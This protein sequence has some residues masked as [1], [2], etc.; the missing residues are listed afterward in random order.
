MPASPI[1]S[2][3]YQVHPM[4]N[5]SSRSFVAPRLIALLLTASATAQWQQQAPTTHPTARR[6]AAMTYLL[7]QGQALLFGG[8]GNPTASNETWLCDGSNWTLYTPATVPGGRQEFEM[9]YDLARTRAVFYGGSGTGTSLGTQ[10]WEFDGTD[11]A[12]IATPTNPGARSR[13]GLSYDSARSRVVMF[14]GVGGSLGIPTN[15]TWEYDGTTWLQVATAHSPGA[16]DRPAMCYDDTLGKTVLFG[17]A[18]SSSIYDLTWV[19]DGVD[20]T[21]VPITGAKPLQRNAAKM[22]YDSFRGVCVLTGGQTA[23]VIYDDTWEFDGTNWTQQVSPKQP[24]RDHSLAFLTGKRLVLEFGGFTAVP[25]SLSD[26]TW[27]YGASWRARGVG[28]PGTFGVPV[29]AMP[30]PGRLGGTFTVDLTSAPPFV[31]VMI[32]GLSELPGLPL[33]GLGMTGCL[34]YASPDLLVTAPI[35]AGAASLTWSPVT[36]PLGVVLHAQGLC[37]DPGVNPA[38]LTASNGVDA[39]LGF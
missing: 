1:R 39:L 27:N 3:P 6:G 2:S 18:F 31:A 9:V 7:A 5:Q 13:Y 16:L 32:L 35:T 33:D 22:V 29:L 28:C 19:Y 34:G 26:Q 17:G 12:Q 10:T 8:T 24:T 23:S 36:A 30:A 11:W 38:W 25:N 21:Q 14:G 4:T 15:Q 20:W 37:L